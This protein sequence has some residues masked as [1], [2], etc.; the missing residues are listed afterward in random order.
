ML[1][2][3]TGALG[4]VD[5]TLIVINGSNINVVHNFVFL[6]SKISIMDD[7]EEV[8]RKMER[9]FG[10][11]NKISSLLTCRQLAMKKR[12]ILFDTCVTLVALYAA[13]TW[14][15]KESDKKY[16]EV[17]QRWTKNATKDYS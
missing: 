15:L 8:G 10:T 17:Y 12:K 4:S 11:F 13:E 5:K 1:H 9:T 14:T 16:I 7:S 6:G 3:L 2:T